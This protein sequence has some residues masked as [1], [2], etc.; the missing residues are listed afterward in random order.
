MKQV[1]LQIGDYA[2][3]E[4]IAPYMNNEAQNKMTS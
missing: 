2:G 3:L 4:Y 1:H